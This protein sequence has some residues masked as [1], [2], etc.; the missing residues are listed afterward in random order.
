VLLSE[1]VTDR[2]FQRPYCTVHDARSRPWVWINGCARTCGD[3]EAAR[4]QQL[5]TQKYGLLKIVADFFSRL[6]RHKQTVIAV[7]FD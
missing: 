1:V 2:Q 4:G 3:D 5:L 6:A 7:G